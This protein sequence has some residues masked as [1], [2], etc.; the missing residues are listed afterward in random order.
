MRPILPAASFFR[1]CRAAT[2]FSPKK[3]SLKP[4]AIIL[5]S[6]CRRDSCGS[7][8]KKRTV[9]RFQDEVAIVTGAGRGIGE[10][11]AAA[12]AADGASV[13]VADIDSASARRVADEIV[14]GGGRAIAIQADVA[15]PAQINALIGDTVA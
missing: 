1:R 7:E 8:D 12:L 13:V 15:D 4:L 3:S 5:N 2:R 10:S 14:A 9:M 11:I 6:N